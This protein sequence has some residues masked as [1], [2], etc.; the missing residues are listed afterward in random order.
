MNGSENK[1][2]EICKH[3]DEKVYNPNSKTHVRFCNKIKLYYDCFN[4]NKDGALEKREGLEDVKAFAQ[5]GSD[6][7]AGLL[8]CSDFGCNM[9]EQK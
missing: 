3:W 6:Y 7:W 9:W 8:T 2:C 4:W 5:D 1:T